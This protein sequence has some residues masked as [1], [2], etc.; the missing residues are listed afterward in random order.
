MR[1]PVRDADLPDYEVALVAW[2]GRALS[3]AAQA[4][5]EEVRSARI[6]ALLAG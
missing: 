4:F 2:S 5:I 3:P 6:P 1:I